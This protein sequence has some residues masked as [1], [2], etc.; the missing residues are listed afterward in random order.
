MLRDGHGDCDDLTLRAFG[1]RWRPRAVDE[2]GGEVPKKIDKTGMRARGRRCDKLVQEA[3][4]SRPNALQRA[5]CGEE[6]GQ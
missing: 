1:D 5:D 3:L 6:G 2:T 4:D